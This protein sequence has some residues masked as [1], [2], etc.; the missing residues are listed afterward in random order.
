M[1][2]TQATM[3]SQFDCLTP[4][5]KQEFINRNID[6]AS[7]AVLAI[8]AKRLKKIREERVREKMRNFEAR[9]T[10]ID[11]GDLPG[12]QTKLEL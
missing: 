5:D 6:Q 11:F 1:T 10:S 12:D 4:A 3:Q 8:A 7:E 9:Q 2:I